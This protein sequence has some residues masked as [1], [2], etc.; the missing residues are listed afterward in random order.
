[1]SGN[2]ILVFI[3][4]FVFLAA[5]GEASQTS[6]FEAARRLPVERAMITAFESLGPQAT[7]DQAAD[8]LIRTTQREFP[9]VDGG[10]QLRGFLTRDAMIRALKSTGPETPVIN[11]M[12]ADPVTVRLGQPLEIAV[13]FM[14]EGRSPLVGVVDEGNRLRGYISQE[15]LA[16]L[17]MLGTGDE[18]QGAKA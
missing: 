11:A 18:P 12:V 16:E 15:N 7:I 17:M 2:A 4:V 14:Q 8:A 6:L 10:G 5:A 9:V 1:M 3:A 13:R